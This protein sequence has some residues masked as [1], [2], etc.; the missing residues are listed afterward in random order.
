MREDFYLWVRISGGPCGIYV[1]LT[2]L[3]TN[4][5]STIIVFVCGVFVLALPLAM[6]CGMTELRHRYHRYLKRTKTNSRELR[7]RLN[8]YYS[9]PDVIE[10]TELNYVADTRV[11]LASSLI[12]LS[13]SIVVAAIY[14]ILLVNHVIYFVS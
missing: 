4:S 13:L 8:F 1:G 9:A 6:F 12:G 11:F 2:L 10:A 14:T 7:D 3:Y 5:I